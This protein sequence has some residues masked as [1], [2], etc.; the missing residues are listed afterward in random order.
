MAHT[1]LIAEVY[2][3]DRKNNH[4]V[5]TEESAKAIL[6]EYGIK[7]PPSA[8]VSTTQAAADKA[9][10]LG[11]PLVAKIVSPE[12]LHKTDVR[13]VKV[14]L[15]NQADVK[16]TFNDMYVRLSKQYHV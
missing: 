9:K 4:S 14:G 8:L 15:Q 13:G 1:D 2:E 5:I 11:F 6:R 10:Q 7:V 3:D 16:D 12:I